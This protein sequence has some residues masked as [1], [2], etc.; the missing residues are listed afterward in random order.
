MRKAE[1]LIKEI[2]KLPEDELRYF[3]KWFESF[4]NNLW[5]K[6]FE[7]DVASGKLDKIAEEAVKAFKAGHYTEL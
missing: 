2:E 4:E 7:E 5:D 1:K 3:S 6:E